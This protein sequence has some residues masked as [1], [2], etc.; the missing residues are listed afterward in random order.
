MSC[1]THPTIRACVVCAGILHVHRLPTASE[2]GPKSQRQHRR[3]SVSGPKSHRHQLT[4]LLAF[5]SLRCS[6]CFGG[7][8]EEPGPTSPS[9]GLEAEEPSPPT[10]CTTCPLPFSFSSLRVTVLPFFFP[11]IYGSE[12]NAFGVMSLGFTF[13]F[14]SKPSV[15]FEHMG[16]GFE[17]HP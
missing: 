3:R 9:F 6:F 14:A 7:W 16:V 4:A 11:R 13:T 2:A 17:S 1:S 8:A 5:C 12:L 10:D 15:S